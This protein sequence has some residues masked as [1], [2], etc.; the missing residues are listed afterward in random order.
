MMT[1]GMGL[2]T[3]NDAIMK[4]LVADLPLGQ[5]ASLRGFAGALAALAV[6]PF[7]GGVRA[8][9]PQSTR[10]IALLAALLVVGLFLFPWS[11]RY[12]T[13]ADAIMLVSLSPVFVAILAPVLLS[14]KVG[15]RRWG[16][17][18]LGMIGTALVLEP[19]QSGFHPAMLAAIA[20]AALMGL[21]DIL[22]RR[23][24]ATETALAIVFTANLAAGVIGLA[25]L[26][27]WVSLDARQWTLLATASLLLT[28]AQLLVTGAFRHGEAASVACLRYTSILWAAL[29]GWLIWREE[30]TVF[31]W[32]GAVLISVSGSIIIVR[33]G[34]R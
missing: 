23:H 17:V 15:W 33:S 26:P 29:I 25:T 27:I 11:L 24:I 5:L 16:A 28:I 19:G 3:L 14:E 18:L 1:V 34:R 20:V 7:L 12:L 9:A 8:L 30:P 13:L 6:A 4:G 21:R 32:A 31:D 10:N 2:L 22:I